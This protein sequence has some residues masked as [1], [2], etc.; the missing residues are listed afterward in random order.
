MK[1]AIV[2]FAEECCSASIQLKVKKL[3][4]S[5][6]AVTR[7]IKC[8]SNDQRDQL[9]HKSKNG[10]YYLIALDITKTLAIQINWLYLSGESN[11]ILR[12]TRNI[13]LCAPFMAQQKKQIYFVNFKLLY[14][15]HN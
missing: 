2:I 14:W 5:D 11:Q 4:L 8:I 3:Q 10:V 13:S 1:Q 15:K 6:N 7:I 12:F 9:V